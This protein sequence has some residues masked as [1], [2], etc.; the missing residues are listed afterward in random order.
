[1]GD[2]RESLLVVVVAFLAGCGTIRDH[3]NDERFSQVLGQR[4]LTCAMGLWRS[5]PAH[6]SVVANVLR[7]RQQ[8][9]YW[10]STGALLLHELP[11]G[12]PTTVQRIYDDDRWSMAE[13]PVLAVGVVHLSG[14]DIPFEYELQFIIG[15]GGKLAPVPWE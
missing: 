8:D 3:T 15:G 13:H 9:V 14:Q 1:M 6:F 5:P 2:Y 11:A 10:R 4:K 12:T 7:E